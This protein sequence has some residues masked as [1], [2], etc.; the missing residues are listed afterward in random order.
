VSLSTELEI[1][2][3]MPLF[4]EM[5]LA[6]LKLLAFTSDHLTF[7][8][9]QALFHQ[10]DISDCAYVILTGEVDVRINGEDE[11]IIVAHLSAP[12]LI[13]EM[14]IIT[15]SPRSASVITSET[16]TALRID[17]NIFLELL[18]QFP[19]MAISVM[20]EMARRLEV[21]NQKIAIHYKL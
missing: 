14:G 7:H 18:T 12:A 15:G 1:L 6:R 8:A 19:S 11:Q 16:A 21:A 3:R 9:G 5:D 17:K 13:G 10:G 4:H 2:R 20:R